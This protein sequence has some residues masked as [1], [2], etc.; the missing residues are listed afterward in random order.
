MKTYPDCIPCF[1]RQ[2]LESSRFAGA[3][4][5]TQRR[6]LRMISKNIQRFSVESPPPEVGALIYRKVREWTGNKDPYRRAKSMSNR[7]ALRMY[8]RLKA[9]VARSGDRLLTAVKLAIAGN[10]IDYGVKNSLNVDVE[11]RRILHEEERA[12]RQEKTSR[13]NY[14]AFCRAA[15]KAQT[16]L[17]IG[18][19]AGEVVFDRILIEEILRLPGRRQMTYAVKSRPVINDAL[20]EDALRCGIDRVAEIMASGTDA[21]GTLLKHCSGRFRN[22]FRRADMVISKGQGNFEALSNAKRPVFFLFMAKCPV[23]ARHVGCLLGEINLIFARSRI[24]RR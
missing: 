13:F 3:N 10:I 12:I 24:V 5:R 22:L 11:L 8:P 15:A 20:K 17:Y 18:D 19:N 21:P 16:I 14:G 1:L 23:V 7:L 9:K 4:E 2:A 6:I